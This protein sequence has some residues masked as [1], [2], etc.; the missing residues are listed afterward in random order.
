LNTLGAKGP[1]AILEQD[2]LKSSDAS[3]LYPNP[4]NSTY[5]WK[6]QMPEATAAVLKVY[7]ISGRELSVT[8]VQLQA[9]ETVLAESCQHLSNGIYFLK[10]QAGDVHLEKKLMIVH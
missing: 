1:T 4:A 8:T 5:N 7:D 2:K 6:V 3:V 9:G 10:L